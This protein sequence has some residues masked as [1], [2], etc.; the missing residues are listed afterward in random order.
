ML[1]ETQAVRATRTTQY[2][3]PSTERLIRLPTV[4]AMTALS[5]S[6]IYRLIAAGKFPPHRKLHPTG[7]ASG[8]LLADI[9]AFVRGAA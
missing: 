4:M 5:R 6:S 9:E 1:N 8:W 2:Q 3:I 7:R